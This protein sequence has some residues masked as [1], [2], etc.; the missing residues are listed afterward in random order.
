ME[1]MQKSTSFIVMKTSIMGFWSGNLARRNHLSEICDTSVNFSEAMQF[2]YSHLSGNYR[3]KVLLKLFG[4]TEA[5]AKYES[6][7]CD[8]CESGLVQMEDRFQK[9]KVLITA[10]DELGNRGEV[11]ITDWI[12]GGQLTW[13][14]T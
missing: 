2:C 7:C 12:R 11:K 4:E 5:N 10:I 13:M 6:K 3:R 1:R 9:L 8:I 14:K